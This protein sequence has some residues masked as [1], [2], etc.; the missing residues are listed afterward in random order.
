MSTNWSEKV[1]STS[2]VLWI[3][4]IYSEKYILNHIDLKSTD[5]KIKK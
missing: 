4:T 3:K 5:I 2:G 1:S